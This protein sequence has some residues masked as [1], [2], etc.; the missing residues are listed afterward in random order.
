MSL[1]AFTYTYSA[2]AESKSNP[3]ADTDALGDAAALTDDQFY[4]LLDGG[5]ATAGDGDGICTS[6]SVSGQLAIDGADSEEKDFKRR[7]N[8]GMDAPRRVSFTSVNNNSGITITLKGKNGS[9]L[10]V[11]ETLTGPNTASVYSAN[12][13]SVVELIYTDSASNALTVGDNAGY[14]DF[15]E[16]AR[17][18]DITSNGNSTAITYT[19]TGLDVYGAVASEEITGPSSATASGSTYFRFVS[20]IG[21][22]SSDSNSISGGVAA[23][24]R[25]MINNQNSR[26]MN[27][28][29]VQA[30]NAAEAAITLENGATSSASGT[31]LLTFNPGMGDGVVNYPSIGDNGIRFDTAMSMDIAVDADLLT[32]ST[33]MYEG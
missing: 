9:G 4:M 2:V 6:Q 31:T 21:A 20:S 5:M 17:T 1:R 32:S 13:Y 12:L 11:S 33:F 14:V 16:L 25:V 27:W 23:G 24:I 26:L 30:A 22:G 28:Y 19:V 15:G 8:Y 18:V 7:V 29:L 3:V 10:S